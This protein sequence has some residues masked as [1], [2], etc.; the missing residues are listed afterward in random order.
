VSEDLLAMLYSLDDTPQSRETYVRMPFG[1]PGNKAESAKYILPRLPYRKKYVEPFGGTGAILALRNPSP[2]EVFNDRHAGVVAFYRCLREQAKC[3][4]LADRLRLFLHSRE[5]FIWCKETWKNCEDDVERAARWYYMHQMSFANQGR[6][7]GRSLK[8]PERRIRRVLENIPNFQ[9]F[10][11][12]FLYVSIENQDWRQC[13][14]DFDS[15]DT[16]YYMDPTYL[17][18][19]AS[20]YEHELSR[21]DHKEMLDRVFKLHGFVA[22]SHYDHELYRSY[23]WD[24]RYT[25]KVNVTMLALTFQ[26]ENKLKGHEH[27]QRTEALEVLW[28]KEAKYG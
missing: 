14:E 8:N 13:L 11:D 26:E 16:V 17:N 3:D 22:M 7:Y 15:Q 25:W 6:H 9:W 24:A 18:T 21:A 4:A 23:P 20:I 27:L 5:E 19:N 12:R 10:H 2:M 1:Y 28:I